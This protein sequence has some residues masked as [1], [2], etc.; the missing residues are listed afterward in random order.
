MKPHYSAPAYNEFPPI[1]HTNF[2]PK[3]HFHSYSYVGNSENLGLEYDFNQSLQM[4]YI[5]VQLYFNMYLLIANGGSYSGIQIFHFCSV[6]VPPLL[7][8][9]HDCFQL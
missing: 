6:E 3:K 2:S 7:L 9:H 1:E 8:I 4:R 5:G